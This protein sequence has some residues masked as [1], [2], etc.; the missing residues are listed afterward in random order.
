MQ[1]DT[2]KDFLDTCL[3]NQIWHDKGT[4]YSLTGIKHRSSI[5]IFNVMLFIFSSLKIMEIFLLLLIFM[6]SSFCDKES[7]Y[8]FACFFKG[9]LG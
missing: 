7:E 6:F 9:P 4:T 8:N 2:S 1:N 5:L 3:M